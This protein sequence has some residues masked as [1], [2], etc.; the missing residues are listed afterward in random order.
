MTSRD[1]ITQ[2]DNNA[3]SYL[4]PTD[5][6][7]YSSTEAPEV[8]ND[9]GARNNNTINDF[10]SMND[11]ELADGLTE[12]ARDSETTQ[13]SNVNSA[14]MD[15]SEAATEFNTFQSTESSLFTR[16]STRQEDAAPYRRPLST[17]Q[18][19]N[20]IVRSNLNFANTNNSIFRSMNLFTS[21]AHRTGNKHSLA[22]KLKF[23]KSAKKMIQ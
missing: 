18:I 21:M 14:N 20:P 13:S 11:N 7:S 6:T 15:L 19:Q 10:E 3:D 16:R 4:E 22:M 23:K 5:P 2:R 9:N 8:D 17:M 1:A 12:V